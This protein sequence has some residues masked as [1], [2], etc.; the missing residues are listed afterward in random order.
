VKAK[1]FG[2]L[3]A[4]AYQLHVGFAIQKNLWNSDAKFYV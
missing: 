2:A 3:Q 4:V 1:F